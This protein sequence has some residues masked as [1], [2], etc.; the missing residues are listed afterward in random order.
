MTGSLLQLVAYGAQDVYIT[1]NPAITFFKSVYR[2][3]TNFA[4]ESIQNGFT[5]RAAFGDK[6]TTSIARNGDLLSRIYVKIVL[7]GGT[8]TGDAKWAWVK[9]IGHAIIHSAEFT[10]GGQTIDKHDGRWMHIWHEL[11]RESQHDRS[12]EII[13][14]NTEELTTLSTSHS[15]TTLYIPLQFFFCRHIG[16][17]LPLIAMQYHNTTISIKFED[18]NQLIVTSGFT[19]S[20]PAS[21]LGLSIIDATLYCDMIFLDTDERRRFAQQPHELLVEQTQ[22]VGVQSVSETKN[23]RI[24]LNFNHPVKELVWGIVPEVFSN[25]NGDHKFLWYHPRDL[26]SMRLIATKRFALATAKY[27]G[28]PDTLAFSTDF[29]EANSLLPHPSLPPKLADI[30]DRIKPVAITTYPVVD[31]VTVLGDL[32]TLEELSSPVMEL[33]EGFHASRPVSVNNHGSALYDVVLRQPFHFGER[34]DSSRNPLESAVIQLNGIDRFSPR[35]HVFFNYIQPLQHHSNTPADGINVY[36]FALSPEEHQ[37]SGTLNFSRVDTAVLNPTFIRPVSGDIFVYA[38]SY[39][40]L[41]V[42]S[43]M[44]GLAF[45]N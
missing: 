2:R 23:A 33:L 45:S 39:N 17:C 34:I 44:A 11:S 3:H 18:V 42:M 26:D 13:I 9:N 32:L 12:H 15:K 41:R 16:L 19:S 14:G 1:G 31:N 27:A 25:R 35:D 36:S 38:F 6:V 21:E 40:I 43:G 10:V 22:N 8:A 37:P 4:V 7:S 5:G 29:M 24:N 30:F 20:S 28:N